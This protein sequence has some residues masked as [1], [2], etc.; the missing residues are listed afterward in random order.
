MTRMGLLQEQMASLPRIQDVLDYKCWYL[1]KGNIHL[2]VSFFQSA[3][4]RKTSSGRLLCADRSG[5]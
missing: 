4:R 1:K 3:R 2:D 5:A